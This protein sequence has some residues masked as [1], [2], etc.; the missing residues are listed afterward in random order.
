MRN[1]L[2]RNN[3]DGTFSDVTIES[4]LA[5]AAYRTHSASW[6]DFDDDGW[7]DLYVGHEEAPSQLFRNKG[8]G[9]FVDVSRRSGVDKT[10]F[11]K[12]STWGDYDNDGY[13]DLYV[14]NYAGE[15]F[16]SITTG[17]A[18]SQKSPNS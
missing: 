17:T 4:G 11:T 6:A 13:P 15:N 2:L 12:G 10:A 14:S 16:L 3:A 8:D 18:L 9:T 7:V 1:S 5:S